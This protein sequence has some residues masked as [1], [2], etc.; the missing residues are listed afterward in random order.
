MAAVLS[1]YQLPDEEET[2]LDY[3]ESAGKI[4]AVPFEIAR[5]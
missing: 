3:V 5:T 4:I 1:F 2:F